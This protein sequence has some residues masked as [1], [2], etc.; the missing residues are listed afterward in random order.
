MPLH[1]FLFS[2]LFCIISRDIF[3]GDPDGCYPKVVSCRLKRAEGVAARGDVGGEIAVAVSQC[4]STKSRTEGWKRLRKAMAASY[5]PRGW[6]A[7]LAA[8]ERLAA[9]SRARV[10][11]RPAADTASARIGGDSVTATSRGPLSE[12]TLPWNQPQPTPEHAAPGLTGDTCVAPQGQMPPHIWLRLGYCLAAWACLAFAAGW[13]LGRWEMAAR[14]RRKKAAAAH[15]RDSAM[16]AAVQN[17]VEPHTKAAA[18]EISPAADSAAS[19]PDGD[20]QAPVEACGLPASGA[21]AR[22]D[23]LTDGAGRALDASATPAA[24]AAERNAEG[25]SRDQPPP[26]ERSAE[27]QALDAGRSMQCASDASRTSGSTPSAPPASHYQSLQSLL[28]S[29]SSGADSVQEPSAGVDSLQELASAGA[30]SHAG[31]GNGSDDVGRQASSE[32]L[33]SATDARTGEAA[34]DVLVRLS[35]A[36]GSEASLAD[37]LAG[38]ERDPPMHMQLPQLPPAHGQAR[39]QGDKA[40]SAGRDLD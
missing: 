35:E 38:L 33:S 25:C 12:H 27:G 22:T 11:V 13:M 14:R 26:P 21:Q 9:E 40:L 10:Y 19:H 20:P 31:N 5:G 18:P 24:A 29:K 3:E 16:E 36:G 34:P 28:R 32:V 39:L 7:A 1:F 15:E 8:E 23:C 37:Q 2:S 6:R 30:G 4:E 17:P